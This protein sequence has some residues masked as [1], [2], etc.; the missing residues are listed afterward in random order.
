[1]RPVVTDG[2]PLSRS[3]GVNLIRENADVKR[4]AT[5]TAQLEL[6]ADQ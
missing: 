5:T 2:L 1:L 6:L 3:N 4:N